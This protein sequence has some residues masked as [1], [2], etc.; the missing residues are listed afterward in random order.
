[1]KA[2]KGLGTDEETLIRIV[3][4]RSEVT[5]V[6]FP[7]YFFFQCTLSLHSGFIEAV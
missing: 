4:S 1:M 7:F 3:A 6:Y 2:M 5:T